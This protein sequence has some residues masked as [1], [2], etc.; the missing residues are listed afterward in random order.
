MVG[1]AEHLPIPSSYSR[2][3]AREL[4]LQERDLPR[5]LRGTGLSTDILLPGDETAL[6]GLQQLRVLENAWRMGNVPEFG[7][8][9]GRQLQPSAHGPLGYLTLAC[10]DIITALKT[11]RDFLPARIPFAHLTLDQGENWIDCTLKILLPIQDEERRMLLECFVLLVQAVVEALLRREL[12]EA[13]IQFD[14]PE[15]ELGLHT[16]RQQLPRTCTSHRLPDALADPGDGAGQPRN[17][18]NP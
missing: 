5:L 3:V 10:P 16:T 12:T 13:R 17:C 6:T 4:R 15:P 14:F 18:P 2:I 11:L 9:L 1:T 8:R 7:L